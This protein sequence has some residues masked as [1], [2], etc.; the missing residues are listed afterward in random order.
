[1]VFVVPAIVQFVEEMP[2]LLVQDFVVRKNTPVRQ[3]FV[4]YMKFAF[5]LK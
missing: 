1:M 2:T 3:S 4:S 5:T